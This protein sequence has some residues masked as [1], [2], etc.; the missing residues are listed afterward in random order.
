MAVELWA[1]WSWRSG[2]H[3]HG[4]HVRE[5]LVNMVGHHVVGVYKTRLPRDTP[6]HPWVLQEASRS[7]GVSQRPPLC[8]DQLE[9]GHRAKSPAL[10]A[11]VTTALVSP[12]ALPP[13]GAASPYIRGHPG[14]CHPRC[15]HPP[16]VTQ[17]PATHCAATP[18][19]TQGHPPR[20]PGHCHLL[21]H[22]GVTQGCE[23]IW[24][25]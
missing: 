25:G 23:D 20:H 12:R 22:P 13:M 9:R 14:C 6:W 17:G 15:C 19:A 21:C 24:E 5:A 2:P 3:V 18:C 8:Q 11:L 10:L 16:C 1:T 4:Q 7:V